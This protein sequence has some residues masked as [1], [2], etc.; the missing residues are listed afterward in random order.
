MGT[1]WLRK[2]APKYSEISWRIYSTRMSEEDMRGPGNGVQHGKEARGIT[3]VTVSSKNR[4]QPIWKD[5]WRKGL[6]K[7]KTDKYLMYLSILGKSIDHWWL[8]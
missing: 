4:R 8:V 5:L 2:H 3:R 7:D 1:I 6:E